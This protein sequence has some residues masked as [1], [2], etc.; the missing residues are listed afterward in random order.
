[1]DTTPRPP[2]LP[3]GGSA[4][5]G[6]PLHDLFA[7]FPDRDGHWIQG[8]TVWEE[9]SG[10]N[11][12]Y[13]GGGNL[14]A[15]SWLEEHGIKEIFDCTS[16]AEAVMAEPLP[17]RVTLHHFALDDTVRCA[18]ASGHVLV[19]AAL[20][21]NQAMKLRND[22]IKDGH[23]L[24]HCAQGISRSA[25][26]VSSFLVLHRNLSVAGALSH[27]RLRRPYVYPNLGFIHALLSFERV[28]HDESPVMPMA[29][30]A[31]GACIYVPSLTA[32]D[33]QRHR[34]FVEYTSR[35]HEI[36]LCTS[37]VREETFGALL[38]AEE[39]SRA[40]EIPMRPVREFL[41]RG[42]GVKVK[43]APAPALHAARS[44]L[45]SG[46]SSPLLDESSIGGRTLGCLYVGGYAASLAPA[47]D[48]RAISAIVNCSD[49]VTSSQRDLETP[50]RSL[51][52]LRLGWVDTPKQC[53]GSSEGDRFD[54]LAEA[55][56]FI[57]G[58]RLRGNH[59]LVHCMAG[60]SRSG[61]V[62]TAY[63]MAVEGLPFEAAL[64]RAQSRRR[65]IQPNDGFVAQLMEFEGSALLQTLRCEFAEHPTVD[66]DA[67]VPLVGCGA[68]SI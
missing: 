62:A 18:E 32:S 23:I 67:F 28:M 48:A 24:V 39:A 38:A 63:I 30:E 25:S 27:L 1:M 36:P 7:V 52:F 22:G 9:N 37:S 51:R 61:T 66:A 68:G 3:E 45:R 29:E 21:L 8:H 12:V 56:R 64:A 31:A 26:V 4:H 44:A 33:L 50:P 46:F 54:T 41:R 59:V 19:A 57:H 13:L 53:L 16:D 34:G 6:A 55:L 15:A 10:L 58:E 47:V 35:D 60:I 43:T 65:I 40:A 14:R 11:K 49:V 42:G 17:P 5:A 20:A 2:A